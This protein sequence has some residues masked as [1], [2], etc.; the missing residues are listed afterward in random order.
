MQK[1][2]FRI[3][4]QA[5]KQVCPKHHIHL[6]SRGN[7]KPFCTEC[8]REE[9]AKEEANMVAKFKYDQ[10]HSYL[11]R[12]SLVDRPDLFNCTFAS[13]NGKRND[14]ASN[15]KTIAERLAKVYA[16][17]PK[18]KFNT[19]FLGR[20]GTGKSHLAMA[21][22]NYV[23]K[24]SNQKCLFLSVPR[25]LQS[26]R[27]WFQDATNNIWSEDFTIE[28][29]QEAGLVVIDDLGAESAAGNASSFVQ[30]VIFSIYEANQRIITTTN[31]DKKGIKSTY[32]NRLLSRISEGAAGHVF[33]FSRMPD[34][35]EKQTGD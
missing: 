5:S 14:W 17:D 30:S 16:E 8:K 23:N 21:I 11:K 10:V 22:L 15:Y 26:N 32:D 35:R 6:V 27:E 29:V 34:E 28:R 9:M 13:F 25:L 1:A 7:M 4:V 19:I 12:A 31:L 33:D 24:H 3:A 2:N 18:I 20:A